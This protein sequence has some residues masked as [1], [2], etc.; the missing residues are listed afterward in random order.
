MLWLFVYDVG[1]CNVCTRRVR[2]DDHYSADADD[3]DVYT[4]DE[5]DNASDEDAEPNDEVA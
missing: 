1:L 5:D 3:V 4:S 2:A